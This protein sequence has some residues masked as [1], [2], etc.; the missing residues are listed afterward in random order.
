MAPFSTFGAAPQPTRTVRSLLSIAL[1]AVVML[2]L[3][4]GSVMAA[5][6]DSR[7]VEIRDNCDPASFNAVL[8]EGACVRNGGL[9]FDALI[10]RL[11]A[12]GEVR[13]WRFSPEQLK[14]AAGGTVT[15]VNR[16]GEFHT[17]TEV[18]AFGGGC[19][20]EINAL[21]GLTPVPECASKVRT[22]PSTV[23]AR[24]S[25]SAAR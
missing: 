8:G 17:F 11:L 10:E 15:A 19:V 22:V 2:V 13:S 1:A 16:G 18:A 9:T 6:P 14:L 21:I 4:V 23:N 20:D 7:T 24:S 5:G 25:R 3:V 12:T